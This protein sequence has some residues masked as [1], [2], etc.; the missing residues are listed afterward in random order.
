MKKILTIALLIG[1]ITTGC[2]REV[3]STEPTPHGTTLTIE[4]EDGAITRA[5]STAPTRYIVEIY[6]TPN[7]NNLVGTQMVTSDGVFSLNLDKTKKYYALV[8]ADVNG[9]DTYNTTSLKSVSLNNGKSAVETW[10]GTGTLEANNTDTHYIH[11]R[12]CVS[13]INLYEKTKVPA[14]S[15][16][17][18]SFEQ[19]TLYYVNQGTLSG[20]AQRQES[21]SINSE[22]TISGTRLNAE[23]YYV[24][25]PQSGEHIVSITF[26]TNGAS[27]FVVNNIPLKANR[28]TGIL[29]NYA[30]YNSE[31]FTVSTS[32]SWIDD[33]DVNP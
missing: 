15:T 19:P 23:E 10:A 20:G 26:Q 30:G 24:F 28:E 33:L 16:I 12:R 21:V 22:V 2:Q 18:M 29:G 8:W 9:N 31:N 6:D 14:G 13:K 7:Y 4:V 32:D 25:A 17:T 11:L 5:V 1:A 27:P 3:A